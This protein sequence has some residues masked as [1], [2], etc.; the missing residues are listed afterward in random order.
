MLHMDTCL[1]V[2]ALSLAEMVGAMSPD[3]R[4]GALTPPQTRALAI[5][6]V[7]AA[8]EPPLHD[9]SR[10]AW[11]RLGAAA[12]MPLRPHVGD[13]ALPLDQEHIQRCGPLVWAWLLLRTKWPRHWLVSLCL[14]H[15]RGPT[16]AVY[17]D[18]GY[19]HCSHSKMY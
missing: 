3:A 12:A 16:C 1:Q 2:E 15:L 10:P 17:L 18:P 6:D 4:N 11:A 5:D 13:I 9:H 8:L 7:A 19:Q 14:V